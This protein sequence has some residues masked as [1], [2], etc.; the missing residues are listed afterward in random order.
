MSVVA[1]A[2]ELHG[3]AALLGVAPWVVVAA[4]AALV[5]ADPIGPFGRGLPR[6][7]RRGVASMAGFAAVACG[8]LPALESAAESTFTAHMVQHLLFTSVAAPLLASGRAGASIGRGA[9]R[10]GVELAGLRRRWRPPLRWTHTGTGA[11]VAGI[12]AS[13]AAL[14]WHLPGPYDLAVEY[15]AV[16]HAEH[17]TFFA[18]AW[19]MWSAVLGARVDQH[20]A[21]LGLL[22][23]AI[24]HAGLGGLLTF[25]PR[26]LYRSY[27]EP[28]VADQQLG[29]VLMWVP[30]G[31]VHL[32][33]AA[34]VVSRWLAGAERRSDRRAAL[35]RSRAVTALDG[36][37]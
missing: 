3:P 33:V 5:A 16:H 34:V 7:R 30:A 17:V 4:G 31:M 36:P 23:N 24:T 21:L 32:L 28:G 9:R 6:D 35:V 13:V 29:G 12:V 10:L 22:V 26:P 11:L 18:T 1:H 20:L 15:D 8:L 19:W 2:G 14:V 37:R 25:A 27:V